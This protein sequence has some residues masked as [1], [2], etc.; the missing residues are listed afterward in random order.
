MSTDEAESPKQPTPPPPTSAPPTPFP[1]LPPTPPVSAPP[2]PPASTPFPPTSALPVLPESFLPVEHA[3]YRPRHSTRQRTA[4]FAAVVFFLLPVALLAVGVRPAEFENRRLAEFP[5]PADGFGF[6]TGLDKWAADHIP[7]RD[8][9]VAVADGISRGVFGEAPKFERPTEPAGP[10]QAPPPKD[11]SLDLPEPTAYVQT[12]EGKDDWLFLGDDIRYACAPTVPLADTYAQLDRLRNAV[13]SSG[14]RFVLAVAPNKSTVAADHLPSRYFGK[15][16]A[17]AGRDRFWQSVVGKGGTL[18]LRPALREAQQKNGRS[19]YSKNDSHWT[20]DGSVV[21]ARSLAEAVKPGTTAT[22][23][24][25]RTGTNE[26][27]GDL[28]A[29]LG[30]K[31]TDPVPAYVLAPDGRKVVT[32]P[33]PLTDREPRHLTQ[34]PTT[35][36]VNAKISLIGDSFGYYS[37]PYVASAFADVRLQHVEGANTDPAAMGRLLAETDVVIVVAAERNLV[38][39]VYPML[40]PTA[41]DAIAAE[42]AARPRR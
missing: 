18:D 24:V 39:G 6:F 5:S 8:K 37:A 21:L 15:D 16:C 10:V 27:P 29:L 34:D 23:R 17:T 22:W 19:P 26:R 40:K 2:T 12:V 32:L 42:L 41:V 4:R 36:V 7:L 1:P 35:G 38:G 28:A 3:L 33:P 31:D 13:V 30:R 25:D 9:A 14:R 11:P 20:H